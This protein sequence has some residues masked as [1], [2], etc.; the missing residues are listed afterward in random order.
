MGVGEV[1]LW[2][3]RIVSVLGQ[4]IGLWQAA[5][6]GDPADELAAS[7]E[8]VRAMKRRQALEELS[9]P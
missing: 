6:K 2:L 7:L 9:K 3:E 8:L 1:T 5:K 4:V